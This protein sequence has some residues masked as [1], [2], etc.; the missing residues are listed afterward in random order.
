MVEEIGMGMGLGAR[1]VGLVGRCPGD[2]RRC[3]HCRRML[4]LNDSVVT[5]YDVIYVVLISKKRSLMTLRRDLGI[6]RHVGVPTC[7]LNPQPY[8]GRSH[9]GGHK[10]IPFPAPYPYGHCVELVHVSPPSIFEL[11]Q[12][13]LVV[14]L[15]R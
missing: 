14:Y 8:L 5:C 11:F 12:K 7:P 3:R 9:M 15:K 4:A 10:W 2:C 1:V 13:F 6:V